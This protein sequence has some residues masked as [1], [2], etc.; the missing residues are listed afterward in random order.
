MGGGF[1]SERDHRGLMG[2]LELQAR[3]L[4]SND[5]L[6]EVTRKENCISPSFVWRN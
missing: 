4:S 6:V 2:S 5:L 3:T 1:S